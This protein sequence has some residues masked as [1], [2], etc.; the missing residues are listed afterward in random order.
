MNYNNTCSLIKKTVFDTPLSGAKRVANEIADLIR[1]KTE[2][3][4]N[5][6]LGLATGGT[7]M[8]VYKELV[9][10]HK[11]EALSF[12]NVITFNLDEY[13]PIEPG[14]IQAYNYFMH[15][16]LFKHIDIP[17]ENINIPKGNIPDDKINEY[18]LEY[19]EK[20]SKCGGIDIQLLGIGQTGHIGFNEP[21]SSLNSK[22]RFVELN[23]VTRTD[24]ILQFKDINLVPM[25]AIT[26]GVDTIMKS[27][28]ILMMAW[29]EKKANIVEKAISGVVTSEIPATFL[30]LHPNTHFVLDHSASIVNN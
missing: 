14:D 8:E 28:K 25:H 2:R 13:Y 6:V 29:G 15:E 17:V 21:G 4:E 22:T 12:S 20:I 23:G 18:C 3:N 1:L 5:C 19:D 11:E 10:M 30:Q 16:N 9:R 7:P 24:A 26:M 27:K